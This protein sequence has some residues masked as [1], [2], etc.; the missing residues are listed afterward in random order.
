[1][2]KY[3]LEEAIFNHLSD[4]T[5]EKAEEVCLVLRLPER[6]EMAKV[7]IRNRAKFD[8]G[9]V[10]K[11]LRNAMSDE[12]KNHDAEM[13]FEEANQ[14]NVA[15]Y[16]AKRNGYFW[17]KTPSRVL[18]KQIMKVDAA[19]DPKEAVVKYLLDPKNSKVLAELQVAVT[20]QKARRAVMS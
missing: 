7:A 13:L 15:A 4:M 12:E 14:L 20:T 5:V 11:A 17:L 18:G 19:D 1:M 8:P 16:N 3:R 10:F 2:N 6:G 9:T